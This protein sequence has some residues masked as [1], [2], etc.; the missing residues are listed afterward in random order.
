VRLWRVATGAEVGC[1]QRHT[2]SVNTVT[3]SPDDKLLASG[4]YDGM[5]ILWN[6]PSGKTA[7]SFKGHKTSVTCLAFAPDGKTLASAG[8]DGAVRLWSVEA[9][10]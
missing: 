3:F 1:F 4:S 6:M 7:R 5:I 2:D 8:L 10:K 9:L